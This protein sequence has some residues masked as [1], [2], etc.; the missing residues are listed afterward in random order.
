MLSI[1]IAAGLLV[2][3][4]APA[5]AISTFTVGSIS[6]V[7][8]A[9]SSQNAEAEQAVDPGGA[10]YVY[11][12]WM[13]CQGIGFARS[14]NGGATFGAP[15]SLPGAGS[16]AS[17]TWDPTIAVGPTGTVYAAFIVS[18]GGQYYPVVDASFDHGVS[19]PQVTSD[20]PP[21]PKNWGDRPFLAVGPNGT[22]YLTWDYGPQRTSIAYVC[23]HV[24]SCAFSAGDLNVVLQTSTDGGRTFGK[25]IPISP[26]YPW[27]GADAAPIVVEPNGRVD[28]L[29]QDFPTSPTTHALSPGNNYF[30]SSTD[31][32]KTWSSPIEVGGSVGTMALSEWWIE[33]S[34]AIDAS[35][36]L[37]AVWDTQGTNAGN[38]AVDSGWL[39]YSTDGGAHWST[40][41]QGPS[42][43]TN[44][45]H[46]MQ[47]TGGGPGTAYVGWL[48]PSDPRG[49]A[50]Y[51]RPFSVASGWT[52]PQQQISAQFGLA[53]VW[54]GDTF[55]L[56][57]LGAS[58]VAVSW[59][60]A[61][62]GKK[63][64]IYAAAV[65]H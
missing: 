7:S 33:P 20:I 59:G 25:I 60:S 34:I 17:T 44:V 37:Y 29:Y 5:N 54:A 31:G 35:G 62:S 57:T 48:S 64:D 28:V 4:A 43:Q 63:S 38:T 3:G 61:V 6:N 16:S 40:P 18:K 32:G 55:G 10:G 30:T 52:A 19:F 53:S 14:T 49:Y 22:V 50:L 13:G 2:T 36:D 65:T 45:A 41:T 23:S 21:D 58:K 9:C 56:S 26:G 51:L 12:V 46:I 27:S 24:G 47:V 39:S 8:G 1:A 15:I 11:E 42:D